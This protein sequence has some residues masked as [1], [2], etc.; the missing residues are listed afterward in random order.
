MYSYG[1]IIKLALIQ[2]LLQSYYHVIYYNTNE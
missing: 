2:I 1:K